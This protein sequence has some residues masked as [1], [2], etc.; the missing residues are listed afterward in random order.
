VTGKGDYI[1]CAMFDSL[2]P[3]CSH[4]AG[5]AIA[6]GEAPKS[7]SQRS[8]G[9]AAFYQVYATADGKHVVLG[10]R[11]I[12][13]A[14][15]LLSALGRPD[16]ISIAERPAGEQGE[17][18]A[19]LRGILATKSREDWVV[20]F[21][22]KDVAFAPVLD[23]REA[24]DQPHIAERGLLVEHEGSHMI[25]PAIRFAGEAWQPQSAPELDGD[26]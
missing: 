13:F 6:G 1:D 7:A 4:V 5:S 12:K 23:F 26:G 2:L 9:G 20:W 3:W 18:I 16:L 24:L 25:A 22:D 17:L 19:F 10:G 14:E 21:A 15:N 11:E 8:L